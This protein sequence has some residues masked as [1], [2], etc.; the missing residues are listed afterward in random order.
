VVDALGEMG[1]EARDAATP[2]AQLLRD[3][4]SR[5]REHVGVALGR[6]GLAAI[7]PLS[8]AIQADDVEVRV[9][10]IKAL[11]LFGPEAER[12]VPA[13]RP[14]L[15][16][17]SP[18]VRA[19]AAEALGRMGAAGADA[20]PELLNAL[21]DKKLAVQ[22]EAVTALV[23]MVA[24]KVPG[25]LE[26]VREADR[27]MRWAVPVA[28]VQAA[29]QA[30]NSLDQLVKDL[31][32]NDPQVRTRAALVL[33]EMGPQARPALPALMKA[34]ENEDPH[35]RLTVALVI[36][37]I[38]RKTTEVAN[39]MRDARKQLAQRLGGNPGPQQI[40]AAW[41]NPALQ[42]RFQQIVMFYILYIQAEMAPSSS[43][44]PKPDPL[45]G[46]SMNP[47]ALL[48][49]LGPEAIPAVVAGINFTVANQL[50]HC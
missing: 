50:G 34:L 20:I 7:G 19:A 38:Q 9:D 2:L 3:K 6:I 4:N 24:A 14:A 17:T 47:D 22:V 39:L 23:I 21:Q 35:V 5:V 13:L 36:A 37:R 27:R 43:R 11:A 41:A 48:H 25:L 30:P 1:P 29:A 45:Q 32:D 26:R 33:Q 44:K 16:D 42:A 12:A 49:L 40:R 15:K 31:S 10:A 8:E 28:A 46:G 18:R